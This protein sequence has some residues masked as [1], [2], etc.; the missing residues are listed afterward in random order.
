MLKPLAFR[1]RPTKIEDIIGQKDILGENGILTNSIKEK[2]PIS[3]I[4][5]GVP[6]SGKTT[7]A[8]AYA[9][10]LKVHYIQINAVSSNKS[11]IEN[12]IKEAKMF[13]PTIL[14]IDE[15][16]RLN[17]DKQDIL[18]PY[19]EDGTIYLIGATTANP[20]IAINKALRSRC[21]LLEVKRL[22]EDE[23]L[24]GLNRAIKNPDGF[25]G[26][27]DI[28]QDSLKYIAKISN[29]DFRFALNFLEIIDLSFKNQKISLE[30]TKSINKVPNLA[31]DKDEDDHYNAVS[32]LQKSIRGSD[33][34]ASLY[35][36]AKL[37]AVNDLESISRRLLVTAYEDV[38]L[39]NPGACMRC[40]IAI[41][42]AMQVGLPE[43]VIPLSNTVIELALSPK[44]K[45]AELSMGRAMDLVKDKPLEVLDYL[46]LT[47]VNVDEIDKYPYD[48]PDLWEKMQYLPDLIKNE[49]FY[50]PEN[51]S[52]FEKAL[53]DNY[54]KLSKIK[55]SSNLKELKNK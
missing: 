36:L 41:D 25:N 35:Y 34:D 30:M 10:S 27:L 7:I 19:I 32:A 31:M 26:K 4:L 18:L 3:F 55:R 2:L 38:G 51:K 28:S 52:Q 45:A 11:E 39:A 53:N 17:K 16:H 48:R 21:H 9:Q 44:S 50:V 14:I 42:A 22:N 49:H 37:C 54:E 29:G 20:Y 15:V 24:L 23:I 33:V 8:E 40:K 13:N 12:A 6:G 1:V 5:Y 47:P 43:A 46:K